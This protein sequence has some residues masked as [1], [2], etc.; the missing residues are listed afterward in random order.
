VFDTKVRQIDSFV[1]KLYFS[2][3]RLKVGDQDKS[4]AP[5]NACNTCVEGLRYTYDGKRKAMPFA[6]LMQWHEQKNHYD[7]CYFCMVSV[8]GYNK[9]KKKKKG[10]TFPNLLSAIRPVPDGPD[11]PVPSPPDNLSSESESSSL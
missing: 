9:K 1:K 4:F 6:I 5:H 3:F 8:A 7:D 11:L 10:I 2:Y